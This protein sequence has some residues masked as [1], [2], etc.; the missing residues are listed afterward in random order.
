[1]T[2]ALIVAGGVPLVLAASSIRSVREYQRVV[3]FRLGCLR[4]VRAVPGSC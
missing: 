4:V 2:E 1:M 3:V